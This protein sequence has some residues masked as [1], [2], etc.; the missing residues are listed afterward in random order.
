[1]EDREEVIANGHQLVATLRDQIACAQD[2]RRD[3]ELRYQQSSDNEAKLVAD[4][5]AEIAR[6]QELAAH[7]EELSSRQNETAVQEQVH[8][9]RVQDLEDA[10]IDYQRLEITHAD[11]RKVDRCHGPYSLR[12]FPL[13]ALFRNANGWPPSL[14]NPSI[15]HRHSANKWKSSLQAWKRRIGNCKM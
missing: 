3:L 14:R 2:S 4:L 9:K 6:N 10:L 8:A 13:Y 15:K 7:V 5:N 11:M 1:M 12:N